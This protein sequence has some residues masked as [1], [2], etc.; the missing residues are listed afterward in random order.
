MV[1]IFIVL[2]QPVLNSLIYVAVL[3]RLRRHRRPR[4]PR[5]P[6]PPHPPAATARVP[7]RIGFRRCY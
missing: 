1:D 4:R 3:R 2:I 6:R 5:P 7:N